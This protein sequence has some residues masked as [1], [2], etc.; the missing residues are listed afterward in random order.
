[1]VTSVERTGKVV[2]TVLGG[3]RAAVKRYDR[4]DTARFK[5]WGSGVRN[6]EIARRLLGDVVPRTLAT[7]TEGEAELAALEWL[8]AAPFASGAGAGHGLEAAGR[9]LGRIHAQ[10]GKRCGSLD[11]S[12]AFENHRSA[13]ESRFRAGV[14]L[15]RGRDSELADRVAGWAAPRL[16]EL[17]TD[18]PTALVHGDFG[19]ANLL[20]QG[21]RLWVIDWEHARWGDPQEDWA[22]IRLAARFPEP[23]GFGSGPAALEP[24]ERGWSEETGC[25]PPRDPGFGALLEVYLAMCLGTFFAGEPN[26]RLSWLRSALDAER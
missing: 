8:E 4:A 9:L 16:A 19:P 20:G 24:L 13:F 26:P 2:R 11:G 1:V 15:L 22:K 25:E 10:R 18:R 7:W 12:C 21:E 23:N 6:E 3:R 5:C 14:G 17:G